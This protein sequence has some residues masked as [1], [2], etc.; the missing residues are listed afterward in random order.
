MRLAR[1]PAPI[2][3]AAAAALFAV[4][5]GATVPR[6]FVASYGN[7]G[8][9]C[10][11]VAPCRSFAPALAQTAD[12][13]E[14]VVLDSAGYGGVTIAQSVT[15]TAPA[16]VYAGISVAS[17]FP[18]TGLTVD[19]TG[20]DVVL[21]GLVIN[22]QGGYIGID[23]VRGATLHV[24]RCEITGM[25]SYGLAAHSADAGAEVIVRDTTIEGNGEGMYATAG[26]TVVFSGVQVVRNA[27]YGLLFQGGP[28]YLRDT[29][30][31]ENGGVGVSVEGFTTANVL[32]MT[33]DRS[34]I[35]ANQSVGVAMR[36]STSH[37]LSLV[38]SDT[39]IARNNST[40]VSPAGGVLIDS[41]PFPG[42]GGVVLTRTTIDGNGGFGVSAD[43]DG[44]PSFAILDDCVVSGNQDT[45]MRTASGPTIYTRNN[46]IFHHNGGGDQSGN[47]VVLGAL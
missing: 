13:G 6:T 17:L 32:S 16:G 44:Y 8:N 38:I 47:I 31:A 22:G 26:M 4:G 19:G 33:I 21:R 9:P 30:I 45:G 42:N 39:D 10:S 11:R 2:V 37:S 34:R 41:Y 23:F 18:A 7:D 25:N 36:L 35:F 40:L 3:V 14:I 43:R 29:L 28:F 27:G 5:A 15:G 12:R 1:R 46:N 20:I 24:E